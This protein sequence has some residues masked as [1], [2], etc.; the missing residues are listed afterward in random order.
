MLPLEAIRI[1]RFAVSWGLWL[2]TMAAWAAACIWV[3]RDARQTFGRSLPWRFLFVTVGAGLLLGTCL[4]GT[5]PLP[6][7]VGL[8]V[9]ATAAYVLIRD[10]FV[11]VDRR[12]VPF[13]V[14][15]EAISRA[16][17]KAGLEASL[18]RLSG[19]GG[20]ASQVSFGGP[21]VTLLKQD[22]SVSAGAGGHEQSQAA[23]MAQRILGDAVARR[24]TE[25]HLE[26]KAGQEVLARYRIDGMLHTM[27]LLPPAAGAAILSGLKALAG[28]DTAGQRRPQDGAFMVVADG[29]RFDVRF[30]SQ[31]AGGGEK[32]VLQLLDSQR[33]T[34]TG[35]LAGLGMR[36]SVVE[37]L[38]GI[39]QQGRG[40]LIVS[41]PAGSG[42]TT[43]AYAALREI[44]VLTRSI[45]TIE[46]SIP[47]RLDNVSQTA[48]NRA[49]DLTGAKILRSA[50]RHDP[51]VIL[52]DE[53]KDK[54]PADIALQA[55]VTGHFVIAT[56]TSADAATAVSRLIDIGIDATLIQSAVTAVLAQRLVRLLC[57]K[58]KEAY[59]PPED[60]VR[61][62]GLPPDK[63]PVLYKEVG[64]RSCHGTGF[65]GRTGVYELL[66]VD[67]DIRTLLGGRPSADAIYRMARTKGMRTFRQSALVKACEGVTSI[68]EAERATQ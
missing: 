45:V 50:L 2:V 16:I 33:I 47:C 35:A 44:D 27:H 42:R 21:P 12:L 40:V 30:A 4:F 25:M 17:R 43:T 60:M 57:P 46:D 28:I 9:C 39:I 7:F 65:R 66:E 41:G 15:G 32:L 23:V 14:V 8:V 31:P 58:C 52:V 18:Q 11:S 38:R 63:V 55:A 59:R 67:A 22:G 51:D 1:E 20:V 48:V 5:T 53:L 68:S 24:A 61:R 54:E 34:V 13:V 10:S 29:R 3:E 64:C 36:E 19:R 37:S 26:A 56:L 49:T 62:L 6:L